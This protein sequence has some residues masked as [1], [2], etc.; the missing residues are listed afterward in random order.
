[1]V[2]IAK[3]TGA[4]LIVNTDTHEPHDLISDETAFTIALGAG[5]D[6]KGARDAT[7]ANPSNLVK[8]IC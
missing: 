3:E 1:V 7:V 8:S 2:R 4:N 6:E 5:L